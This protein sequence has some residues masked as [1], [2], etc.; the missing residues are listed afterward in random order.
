L[1]VVPFPGT[2]DASPATQII[3]STLRPSDLQSVAA[4]GTDSGPHAGHLTRL[5][6]GAGTAFVPARPFVPGER[7]L[8]TARL[9][10]LRAG[11]LSGAPGR[12]RLAFGFGVA[13][14]APRGEPG[15]I[16]AAAARRAAGDWQSYVS[17]PHLHPPL[18]VMDHRDRHGGDI[19]L[20]PVNSGQMGALIVN[21]RGQLVWFE[22]TGRATPF[23]LEVQRYRGRPVLTWWQGAVVGGHGADGRD[24]ILDSSY[25]KVA[26]LRGGYGYSSDLHEFQLI[27]H[28]RALIDAYVPVRA[29]LS[30]VGGA[31][32]GRVLDCVIQELDVR[33]GRVLWEWHALG[34]VPLSASYNWV[35]SDSTPFDYFHLNSIQQLSGHRL[36]ISAR[37][38]WAVYMVDERTGRVMWTLGGRYSSYRMGPGTNFEW[39]HDARM[40]RHGILTLFDDG[41]FPEEE[42]ESS[43]KELF[44]NVNTGLVSV[45]RRFTHSPPE[46]SGSQGNA[47]LLGNGNLMIGWG[48]GPGFSEYT[49]GGREL[50]DGRFRLGVNS[51]RAYRFN[52]RGQPTTP[53]SLAV[54]PRANGVTRLYASWNGATGV[55]SW[56]ILGGTSRHD[57]IPLSARDSRGFE[58]SMRLADEAQYFAVRALDS[59]GNVLG[60]S[61]AIPTP[62]HLA[63]FSR[64]AFASTSTGLSDIPVGCFA[65]RSCMV[66]LTIRARKLVMGSGGSTIPAGA[67]ALVPISVNPAGMR[68]L[69]AAAGRELSIQVR[70]R[71]A[72]GPAS[73][74]QMTLIA[75]ST[76]GAS[77]PQSAGQTPTVR[78]LGTSEFVSRRGAGG[79]LAA[80]SGAVPCP[81]RAIVSV[82]RTIVAAPGLQQLGANEAGLV[83]FRLTP[84]GQ[85]MLNDAPGNQ[86]AARVTLV[87]GQAAA[88]GQVVLSRYG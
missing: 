5:P 76:S 51:Y 49:P 7:V 2:P 58:T 67:I 14:Q 69:V 40:H 53:P 65:R 81:I 61:Y 41:A 25:H 60:R 59:R 18:V 48:A 46:L 11:A 56:E 4:R 70:A 39:Q 19:F 52:W 31:S 63:I 37:N 83:G 78:L 15:P 50:L 8:V 38:T 35:P 32:N 1:A 77:P 21:G 72:R 87:S 88:G 74:R 57:L 42:S 26:A 86:L 10:S 23:N 12:R 20:T 75:Y 6:A 16:P 71:Q 80:C 62:R 85:A 54:A 9:S 30:S 64:W 17:E 34:H 66:S 27:P 79:I 24:M 82:G 43:A 33:T 44:V 47:Q 45:V 13:R 84:A 3:F 73:S 28:G 68:A 22:H 55:A 29:D 36:I